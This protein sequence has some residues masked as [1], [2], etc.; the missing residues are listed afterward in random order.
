[1]HTKRRVIVRH[2]AATSH[3]RSAQIEGLAYKPS[4]GRY[5]DNAIMHGNVP[6]GLLR[7]RQYDYATTYRPYH[8]LWW[9]I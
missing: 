1:M 2:V 6:F 4:D 7:K 9:K 5:C 3:R 8:L